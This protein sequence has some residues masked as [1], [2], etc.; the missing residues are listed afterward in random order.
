[1]LACPFDVPRYQWD[2]LNPKVTKCDLCRDR[3]LAGEQPACVEVCPTE[4]RVFGPLEDVVA[5]AKQRIE[6]NPDTYYPAVYGLREVGGTSVIYIS[7]RPFSE[8]GL[9]TDLPDYALSELTWAII[10]KIPN[11]VL[12]GATLL[13]GIWWITNRRSEVAAFER[14]LKEMERRNPSKRFGN[15]GEHV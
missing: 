12:W 7:D 2:S 4:A 1:M 8:L 5:L 10:S 13:G 11:Y 9:R 15:D 6:E 3:V 14:T